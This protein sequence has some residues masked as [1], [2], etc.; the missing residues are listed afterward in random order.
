MVQIARSY[1]YSGYLISAFDRLVNGHLPPEE[2][3]LWTGSER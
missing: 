1:S 2:S 3:L